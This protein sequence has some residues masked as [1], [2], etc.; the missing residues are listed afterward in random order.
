MSQQ[1]VRNL[2]FKSMMAARRAVLLPGAANALTA[3]VIEDLGF[4]A[5]YLTG[6]GVSNTTLALPDLGFIGLSD[7]V[8][9]TIALR[10]ATDLPILVDADTGFG[11]ALNVFYTVR[12]IEQAGANGIQ[13]ED[14]VLPKK[15]GHFAGK[16]VVSRSEAVDRIRAAVEA[17]TD[18]NFQIIARTDARSVHGLDEALERAALFR[19]AGADVLF[20]EAPESREEISAIFAA[21][22]A[23]HIVNVVI[24]GKT[25]TLDQAE[26]QQM[27]C[28]A[29]LYAN[30][31]LQSAVS[32]MQ[33]AL[34]QLQRDGRADEHTPGIA[35]FADRQRLVRK[36]EFD[37]LD[38]RYSAK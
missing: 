14:Q 20:V 30:I 29:L 12:A 1:A 38:R 28:S 9:H 18:P 37:D 25:P 6:A 19:A 15:C 17:R 8:Q 21:V 32:G 27:G 5:I 3:R 11:N 22:D 23:P 36:A 26:A 35:S 16:E 24:G 10:Q 33:A 2:A 4:E 7:I 31:A 34:G 13:L